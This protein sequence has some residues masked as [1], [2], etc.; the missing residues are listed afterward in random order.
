[1]STVGQREMKTQK[2]VIE[3]F[4]DTLDYRYLGNWKNRPD[5]SDIEARRIWFNL[6]LAKKTPSYTEYILVHEMV[7]FLERNHNDQFKEYM[8]HFMPQWRTHRDQLNRSPL[9]HENWV[10]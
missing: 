8:D 5:N 4:Q 9:A 10:C 1:M 6:E 3:F 2:Y 7:H